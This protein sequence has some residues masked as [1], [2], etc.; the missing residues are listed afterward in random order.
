MPSYLDFDSTKKFRDFILGKTLQVDGGPQ[1]FTSDNYI[2]HH[3]NE[4]SNP[5]LPPVDA[6]RVQDLT[7][8]QSKNIF[9]PNEYPVFEDV[10]TLQRR[11]NL[12]LYPYYTYEKHNLIG[13]L[14][15]PVTETESELM[16]F[17]ESYLKSDEGPIYARIQQN[18]EAATIGRIRLIDALNGSI[19]TATNIVTGKEP[20][21]ES[22]YKITVGKTLPGKAIDFMQTVAGIEFP[23]NEIPG[24]YLTNPNAQKNI[25]PEA[26]TEFD[27]FYQDATGAIGSLFNIQRR[28]M[29]S[30]KPSD[31]LIEY[32][33]QGQKNL[34]FDMLSYST[35]APNYTTTARS[36]NTSKVFNFIDNLAQDVK[37]IL[38]MEAP[39]GISYIGDDRSENVLF[40]MGDFNDN[41]IKSPFY[42]SLM[43]DAT[44]ATLF[45]RESN[46]TESGPIPGVLTWISVNSRNKLGAN[47][48]TWNKEQTDFGNTESTKFQFRYGSILEKTQALLNTLP[49]NGLISREHVANIIDQTS[50]FFKDGDKLISRGSNIRYID[51]KGIESGVELCRVWTKDRPYMKW[52]DTMKRTDTVRKYDD[53]VLSRPWNLNIAPISNGKDFE[54]GSSTNIFKSEFADGFY[55]KKYMFSLENLAWKSSNVP[56]F[57]YSDLPYCERGPSGGRVM[58]FPPY[59]L[60]VTEQTNAKWETNSFLGRPEPIYTYQDTERTGQ[61][62]FKVIVD[63]PSILNLL[64]SEHFKDMSDEDSEN[65]INA[66]FAGCKDLDFYTL[67]NRYKTITPKDATTIIDYLNKGVGQQ[68]IKDY[69]IE[70]EQPTDYDNSTLNNQK[71]LIQSK[72]AFLNDKPNAVSG[73]IFESTESYVDLYN[74]L[75]TQK[76]YSKNNLSVEIDRLMISTSAKDKQDLNTLFRNNSNVTTASRDDKVSRLSTLF[77]KADEAYNKFI[78]GMTELKSNIDSGRVDNVTIIVGTSTSACA[79]RGYNTYLSIRRA[80][81]IYK[82]VYERLQKNGVYDN[83]KWD[84][85]KFGTTEVKGFNIKFPDISQFEYNFDFKDLGYEKEGK[86]TIAF[87]NSAE[88]ALNG[89]S[90]V[91][92]GRLEFN[93]EIIKREAPEAFECRSGYVTIDYD[94]KPATVENPKDNLGDNEPKPRTKL[95]VK[96]N[97]E[98]IN[99]RQPPIDEMKKIISKTLSECYY[100]KKLED[101][102]PVVFG[103]LKEKLRYFHPAFH[104]MTPE[105]LNSRLTFIQQCLRPGNT[106]P[107]KGVNENLDL[108]ARNT[109]FGA[110]PVCV[111]RIGDFFNTKIIINNVSITYEDGLWDLNPEGIGIQPM[112]ADVTIQ[113]SFI[114]GSGIKEPVSK[115]QNALSSNFYANTEMYDERAIST[116]DTIAGKDRALFTKEF[117]E[118]INSPN[119]LSPD[120]KNFNNGND[121]NEDVYIGDRIDDITFSYK[122]IVS[123]VFT[124]TKDYFDKYSTGYN[125]IVKTYGNKIGAMLLDPAYRTI[126]N[127]EVYTVGTTSNIELVG[128][129]TKG[130]DLTRLSENFKTNLTVMITNS[131][132]TNIIGIDKDLT[133][134]TNDFAEYLIKP[135]LND[136]IIEVIDDIKNN[137]DIIEIEKARDSLISALD[138]PNFINKYGFDISINEDIGTKIEMPSHNILYPYYSSNIDYIV[139]NSGKLY[140]D[141][142]ATSYNFLSS[143]M[144]DEYFIEFL[145]IFLYNNTNVI[146]D[147]IKNNTL[148][149]T[150]KDIEKIE[151]RLNKFVT[152]PERDKNFK[153]TSF[154]QTVSENNL[155][156]TISEESLEN[157]PTVIETAKKLFSNKVEITGNVLNYYKK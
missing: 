129:Y 57:T 79:D 36:Q 137:E 16:K 14:A 91:P 13:I 63:H 114:G 143:A 49:A 107:I 46:I 17:A 124:T 154:K 89:D 21:V 140:E 22:N 141:L 95:V 134:K 40:A 127:Y 142:D 122:T 151:K 26:K 93:S 73:K 131:S 48:A 33:G 11:A 1:E 138:K 67:I 50:R 117:L 62:S 8:P 35:Y 126:K 3:T 97:E 88:D 133:S 85:S 65:A 123:D 156:I 66:F 43:F 30:R 2:V 125:N 34:L 100:F 87:K 118:S 109:S 58:W 98:N 152:A 47:N 7:I 90:K 31:L 24:D 147:V 72:L 145:S 59:D 135:A 108:R 69:T 130:K 45:Q 84:N 136:F 20:L 102:D 105:G 82:D 83:S 68:E 39:A 92:C 116:A 101:T 94:L 53:S 60:K 120:S 10:E 44:Q 71:V 41:Q 113:V 121:I 5:D 56:G 146:M 27:K 29:D 12:N 51:S 149:F 38:G 61:I 96:P 104:S 4:F 74:F 37:N 119:N 55:A 25:R 9:K 157:D 76:D 64:V 32:M 112:I 80:H 111:L 132:I 6:N 23:W 15:N 144:S 106:I 150:Q 54:S 110:P 99:F 139:K 77:D 128:V 81:S 75:K 42:L 19:S 148:K 155:T 86:I 28:P 103:S 115:L 18:L 70:Y 52:S 78:S 153:F